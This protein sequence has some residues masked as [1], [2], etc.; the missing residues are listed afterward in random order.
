MGKDEFTRE[1]IDFIQTQLL[2]QEY[3]IFIDGDAI[4]AILNLHIA[5]LL[6]CG[7]TSIQ[8]CEEVDENEHN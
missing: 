2:S 6:E 1:A 4:A 5:Y 7:I 8:L 3:G